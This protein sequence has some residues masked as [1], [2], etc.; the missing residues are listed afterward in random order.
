MRAGARARRRSRVAPAEDRGL[1]VVI[2]VLSLMSAA[3]NPPSAR[4]PAIATKIA[5]IATTPKSAGVRSRC[6]DQGRGELQALARQCIARAPQ[7]RDHRL[8]LHPPARDTKRPFAR[9]TASTG[10]YTDA[11]GRFS[12]A[13]PVAPCARPGG[14]QRVPRP[15]SDR[16]PVCHW[17]ERRQPESP[18]ARPLDGIIDDYASQGELWHGIPLVHADDALKRGRVANCST[19]IRPLD[20]LERLRA[21]GFRTIASLAGIVQNR[22]GRCPFHVRRSPAAR[23]A[24]PRRCL[25]IPP[26]RARGRGI[27]KTLLDVLRFRLTADPGYMRDHRVRI[28]QQYFED[29]MA[30]G[31]GFSSMRGIRRRHCRGH[32]P[33]GIRITARSCCSNLPTATWRR[34]AVGSPRFATSRFIPSDSPM[35]RVDCASTRAVVRRPRSAIPGKAK[36]RSKPWTRPSPKPV[37]FIKMDLEGWELRALEGSKRHVRE[38]HPKLAIAAYHDAADLRRIRAFVSSLRARL[39]GLPAPLHPGLVG[40]RAFFRPLR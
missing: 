7:C 15:S 33:R 40:N 22:R 23:N 10:R 16:T 19:S 34:H 35:R 2:D 30:Y 21:A 4:T 28:E 1:V 9:A 25:A 27:E 17:Q 24:G 5:S 36:S 29:F 3:E 11:A 6:G 37:T 38:D 13:G 32:S 31:G 8:P 26:R 20:A 12:R 14:L 18:S 39:R